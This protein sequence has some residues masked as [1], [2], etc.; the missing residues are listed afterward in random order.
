M[1]IHPALIWQT[2]LHFFVAVLLFHLVYSYADE[3]NYRA[4]SKGVFSTCIILFA[5]IGPML[6]R[7]WI[8]IE[9]NHPRYVIGSFI[10][11]FFNLFVPLIG[12]FAYMKLMKVLDAL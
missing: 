10:I 9:L 12:Y 5:L 8:K 6:I 1:R 4:Y 3:E 11:L 7:N 2:L